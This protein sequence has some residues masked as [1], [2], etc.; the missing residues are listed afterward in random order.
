MIPEDFIDL[1]EK[2][3]NKASQQRIPSQPTEHWY[4]N[5]QDGCHAMKKAIIELL[6]SASDTATY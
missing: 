2:A 3:Y 4:N 5:Y 6:I 1:V